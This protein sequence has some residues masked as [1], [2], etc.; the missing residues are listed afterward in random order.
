MGQEIEKEG[1]Q[2]EKKRC[3]QVSKEQNEKKDME[4]EEKRKDNR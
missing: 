4:E 2:G 3:T 1:M